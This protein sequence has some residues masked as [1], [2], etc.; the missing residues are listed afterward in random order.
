MWSINSR[1]LVSAV[2][3]LAAFLGLTGFA[4]DKAF[5]EGALEAVQE[6]L[7]VHIYLLLGAAETDPSGRLNLPDVLPEARFSSPASGLFAE[8]VTKSGQLIWQSRSTLSRAITY[9]SPVKAGESVFAEVRTD[10]GDNVFAM[11]FAVI[12]EDDGDLENQYIFRVSESTDGFQRQVRGFRRSLWIWFSAA[13]GV[14]LV[15]QAIILRWGLAPLRRVVSELGEVERGYKDA[16]SEDYPRE[17]RGLSANLNAFIRYGQAQL[18]RYRNAL[19]DLAHSLKTPLAVLRGVN[20]SDVEIRALRETLSEQ[21][22]RMQQVIDYQLQRAA[23]SGRSPLGTPV[24]INTATGRLIDAFKK[25][26]AE[27]GLCYSID[28]A[29]DTPFY[30]D[31]GD[32]TEILG[33]LIDNASKWAHAHVRISAHEKSESGNKPPGLTLTIEDDGPGIAGN[34]VETLLRRG[35]H[36]DSPQSGQGIGLA[37]VREIVE[38]VYRG[39]LTLTK[40]ALGGVAI[41]LLFDNNVATDL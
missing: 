24:S 15:L 27:R 18:L 40:S 30:G 29:P 1:L 3:V 38:D 21:V 12:W 39:R 4:L 28:M 5:R 10:A 13:A 20:E 41:T 32:L 34:D 23:A 26:Y 16:L 8:V 14:L 19:D 25:V 33:N 22:T 36:S 35:K 11:S 6:R 7:Q 31:E 9:P 17:I 2:A 37:V